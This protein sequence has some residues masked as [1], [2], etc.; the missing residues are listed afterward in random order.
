[1]AMCYAS[2]YKINVVN[3]LSVKYT[4]RILNLPTMVMNL[5]SLVHVFTASNHWPL[6]WTLNGFANPYPLPLLD[7]GNCFTHCKPMCF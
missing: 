5:T 2:I 1:M 7:G 4:L 3:L 6:W